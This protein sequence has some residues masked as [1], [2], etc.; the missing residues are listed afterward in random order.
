MEDHC[1]TVAEILANIRSKHLKPINAKTF[2][3]ARKAKFE[4][5]GWKVS[6][7]AAKAPAP[8]QGQ[9]QNSITWASPYQWCWRKDNH[10]YDPYPPHIQTTI[11]LAFNQYCE[12]DGPSEIQIHVVREIDKVQGQYEI[13]FINFNQTMLATGFVRKIDRRKTGSPS[14]LGPVWHYKNEHGV[15]ERYHNSVQATVEGKYQLFATGKGPAV[16]EMKFPGRA[17][18][19]SLDFQKLTQTNLTYKTS[20]SISRD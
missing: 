3:A 17:E 5:R 12:L 19:Y 10:T 8:V 11:E 4:G 1:G 14:V 2:N 16:V 18:V 9:A 20:R 6:A 7:V 15:K 13:D